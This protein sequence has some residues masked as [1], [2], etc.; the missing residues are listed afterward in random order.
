MSWRR[1]GCGW[2]KWE[3]SL[4]IQV[5]AALFYL[6]STSIVFEKNSIYV[7]C[8]YVPSM[9]FWIWEAS[10]EGC[11]ALHSTL[12]SSYHIILQRKEQG[13]VWQT[14]SWIE[15]RSR[16]AQGKVIWRI[17]R[18][19]ARWQTWRNRARW[20]TDSDILLIPFPGLGEQIWSLFLELKWLCLVCLISQPIIVQ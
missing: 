5:T 17:W 14:E 18:N 2:T 20:Q 1:R 15:G 4:S 8:F 19:R 3:A 9:Y 7:L 10:G 6:V 12:A 11:A 16:D 13:K